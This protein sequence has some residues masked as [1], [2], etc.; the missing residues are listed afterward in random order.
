MNFRFRVIERGSF[1][2]LSAFSLFLPYLKT[3]LHLPQ[4]GFPITEIKK[5]QQLKITREAFLEHSLFSDE[6]N[7]FYR[8][9]NQTHGIKS[10]LI[11]CSFTSEFSW[12]HL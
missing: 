9:K 1:F 11:K 7:T 6:Q 10:L 8:N 4:Q 12:L 3:Y 2:F 5:K